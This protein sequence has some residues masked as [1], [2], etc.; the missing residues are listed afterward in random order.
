MKFLII[1]KKTIRP[2]LCGSGYKRFA[3]LHIVAAYRVGYRWGRYHVRWSFEWRR[4][5]M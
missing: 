1:H 3:S 2:T 4:W 5:Q